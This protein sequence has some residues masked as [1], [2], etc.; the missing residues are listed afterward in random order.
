MERNIRKKVVGNLNKCYC[1]APLFYE[2][3]WHILVGAEKQDPCLLLDQWGN[4]VDKIWDESGGVMSMV[5]I[6]N[7]NGSFLTTQKFY[8]PND[9]KEAKIVR[10]T[11]VSKGN[12]K[13]ETILELP[14]VH[15]FD[16]L[17]RNGHHYLIACTLKSEHKEKDDWSSGGKIYGGLLDLSENSLK[18]T[19][20][21][22]PIFKNHGYSRISGE[23]GCLVTGEEGVFRITPPSSPDEPW[24]RELLLNLPTSD[25]VLFDFDGDG[26]QEL[27]V[28]CPFHGET[29]SI[30]KKKEGIFQ[31]IYQVS[32]P[33][34][35]LHGIYGGGDVWHSHGC[36]HLNW[37]SWW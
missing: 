27:V 32:E 2:N 31:K 17:E 3:Q 13:V 33:L 21:Y 15:R 1:L 8:S 9:S 34:P 10:V 4:E 19:E 5:Q 18:L 35:F 11:P 20:I 28:I 14:F 12:W 6:P 30:Y 36:W 29:C 25:G 26:S 23:N 24:E 37:K 7:T 16:I 22:S